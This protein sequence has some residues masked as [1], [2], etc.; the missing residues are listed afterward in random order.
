ME[1][2]DRPRKVRFGPFEADLGSGELRKHGLRIKLQDQPFQ[3]LTLLLERSGEVVTREELRQKLWSADTFVDF[4]V[5][6]NTAI[7]RLRDALGDTAESPRYIETLPRRGYRFIA[8]AESIASSS[9][10]DWTAYSEDSSTG[11][12]RM[13]ARDKPAATP[14]EASIAS[15]RTKRWIVVGALAATLALFVG[16]NIGGLRQRL[17]RTS[18]AGRIQ[19]IAVLPLENLSTDP[20][21][22]YFADGMT[23][24]II[25]DLAKIDTLRVISRSS[26][27]RYKHSRKSLSEIAKELNV[28]AVVEGTVMRSGNRVRITAQLIRAPNDQH[29]W[30]DQF[31]RE[32]GNVLSLQADVARAIAAKIQLKLTPQ[33]QVRLSAGKQANPEAYDYYLRG[34]HIFWQRWTK[35]GLNSAIRYYTLA[36]DRDPNYAPAYAALAD[37]YT[38]GTFMDRPLPPREAWDKASQAAT[39][40]LQLDDELAQAHVAMAQVHYRYDW[41]WAEADREFKRGIELNPNDASAY[42]GY[43]IFLNIMRRTEEALAAA[44]KAQQLDPLSTTVPNV[45]AFSYQMAGRY[46]DAL[47]QARRTLELD[48]NF[49]PAHQN[50]ARSYEAKGMWEEAVS[51]WLKAF[52]LGGM[53]ATTAQT[54]RQAYEKGGIREF[55]RKW[56]ELDEEKFRRGEPSAYVEMARLCF[57]LG[58]K[59]AGFGWLEKAYKERDP[60]LPGIYTNQWLYDSRSDPRY[61]DLARRLGLPP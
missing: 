42:A 37:C 53:D 49:V 1:T 17:L 30:A 9:P 46:D 12:S 56:L 35:E 7:K 45:M 10:Q 27:L 19:A 61:I 29:V 41:N 40:A 8:A 3:V 36:I 15:Q 26:V 21:Q 31:E 59:V 51:E 4:D 60:W 33:Q 16:L 24:E 13:P 11:P 44:R 58:D 20:E 43:S 28:D 54:F 5:G 52:T 25:T 32:L 50:L 57:Q 34:R 22:E 39:K 6:L 18:A 38:V 2:G 48:P 14:T 55:R 23:D 47:Q